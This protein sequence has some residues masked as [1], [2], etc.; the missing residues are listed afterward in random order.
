MYR[1]IKLVKINS[2]LRVCSLEMTEFSIGSWTSVNMNH[3]NAF[4]YIFIVPEHKIPLCEL[5]LLLCFMFAT[6]LELKKKHI[7]TRDTV[8]LSFNFDSAYTFSNNFLGK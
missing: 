5:I 3:F 8:V 4:G 2:Y 6:Y 1:H 7:N